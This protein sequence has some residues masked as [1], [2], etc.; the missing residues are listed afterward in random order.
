[1]SVL[2]AMSYGLATISTNVGGI[3]QVIDNGVNG[4]RINAGNVTEIED[5]LVELLSDSALRNKYGKN[6]RQ[7]IGEKFNAKNN[8]DKIV[9]IYSHLIGI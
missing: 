8:I 4:V 2:E 9:Y 7:T 1:M 3:P 6:A 5:S